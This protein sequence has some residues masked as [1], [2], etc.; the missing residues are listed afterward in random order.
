MDQGEGV[1]G[2]ERKEDPLDFALW[3]AHKEGED[4]AWD[5]PWGRGPPGLAHRV[6]GDGRGAARASASTSTAAART[7]SSPTTRT[8]RRRRAR[9]AARE[10]ARLWMHNG[11]V[12]LDG[13]ED[14]QVGRQHRAAARGAR[15]ATARDAVVMYFCRRPLPP[16]ARLL[17]TSALEQARRAASSASARRRGGS[18]RAPSPGGAG[19]AARA[20]SS[21]RSPTTSTPPRRSRRC[22][23]G[24]ARRNRRRASRWATR[25]LREMLGVLGLET[26]LD[27]ATPQAPAEVA[28]AR[29]AARAGAR[30]A[31]LRGGRPPARRARARSAGR[32]ATAPDGL[33][34]ARRVVIL[35]GRNPVREALRGRRA[36][37]VG[38]VWATRA[39]RARAVAGEARRAGSV[40]APRRSSGAAAPHAHQ[41]VCAEVGALPLRR[42]RRAAGRAR[43][44]CSSRSTRSRTRRTSAR[45]AARAECA[46]ATGV[47]IPERRAAEVTPAVCKASAGAVEHLP[48]ARVRN[49]ADFL[50]DAKR[51]GCWC[52]GAERR[53]APPP[54]TRPTT[55]G[56][57]VLV[58]GSEGSGL[59]PRVAERLRRADRAA[60]ARAGRVAQRRAPPPRR[61]C[62]RSCR[63][64]RGA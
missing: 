25:D 64:E 49:L 41:G 53:R 58:L 43:R 14:G 3:K 32:S 38:E 26:L 9:R 51:A 27:A 50:A 8:R 34:A 12:Q 63:R 6:L 16:A 31:R 54:T 61:S 30:R 55:R 19:A 4:T 57:V 45:S 48:V 56:G 42:R 21:T 33:R 20:R 1:E 22:S 29:R 39:R 35:Y 15:R 59:R 36:T 40:D 37:R 46:G 11:M 24:C 62:T 47:V 23:S 28:R 5:A 44:R 7:S 10:L 13:R 60:A 17:A 2:A 18:R 52:Y